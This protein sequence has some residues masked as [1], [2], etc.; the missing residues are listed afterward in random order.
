MEDH[1]LSL[2]LER[3]HLRVMKERFDEALVGTYDPSSDKFIPEDERTRSDLRRHLFDF[4][5]GMRLHV[6][7]HHSEEGKVIHAYAQWFDEKTQP[8]H[9]Q[10]GLRVM[11][12]RMIKLIEGGLDHVDEC[13][14]PV[15]LGVSENGVPHVFFSY[16]SPIFKSNS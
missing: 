1:G 15:D 6:T 4:M 2:P 3:E 16:P 9:R 13:P 12:N 11:L 5:D 7:L 14:E 8:M 10:D